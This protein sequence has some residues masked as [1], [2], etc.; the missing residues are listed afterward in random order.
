LDGVLYIGVVL[1]YFSGLF[2]RPIR[3]KLGL[4]ATQV[5]ASIFKS[6]TV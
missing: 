6:S 5:E 1:H 4:K 2:S 3:H